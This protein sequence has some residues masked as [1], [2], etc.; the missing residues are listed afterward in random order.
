MRTFLI[1]GAVTALAFGGLAGCRP[2][3]PTLKGDA[4]AQWGGEG[5]PRFAPS[6]RLVIEHRLTDLEPLP[7]PLWPEPTPSS[8]GRSL[9]VALEVDEQ[10]RVSDVRIVEGNDYQW[11]LAA[12]QLRQKAVEQARRLR[13][14]PFIRHGRPVKAALSILIPVESSPAPPR[15]I[16]FPT[17]DP[18]AATIS[19]ERTGCFGTCPAYRVTLRG[20]GEVTWQ[21]ERFVVAPIDLRYRIDPAAVRELFDRVR[22][23]TFY[24]LRDDY[25]ARVTDLPAYSVTVVYGGQRKTVTDYAGGLVGMPYEVT[26]LEEA[27]D[28]AARTSRWIE[29]GPDTVPSLLAAGLD[30]SSPQAGEVVSRLIGGRGDPT[31]RAGR[32]AALE[33]IAAGAPINVAAPLGMGDVPQLPLVSAVELGDLDL[34]RRLVDLGALRRV[35][36][37]MLGRLVI[38]AAHSKDAAMMT[39]ILKLDPP[40]EAHDEWGFKDTPLSIAASGGDSDGQ[41]GVDI[42]SQRRTV[43]LLISKGADVRYRDSAGRTALH[44][45]GDP[46]IARMLIA[47]GAVIEAKSDWNETPLL[48]TDSEDVALVLIAA[49]ADLS[50][51]STM[52]ET[53]ES[54][55]RGNEWARV[56]AVLAKRKRQ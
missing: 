46:E 37:Q 18:D 25:Q 9:V 26:S 21:G 2:A 47:A 16:A 6:G 35:D 50:V 45:V 5:D 44:K 31:G 13:F 39:E 11:G 27:I 48:A 34:Y 29:P 17:G 3:A 43:A 14:R 24:G 52:D 15:P 49:G 23:M 42:A 7:A 54:R 41:F 51:T 55:A 4:A 38:A 53:V 22:A 33:L 12:R 28:R 8:F 20:D 1:A 10:G 56:L 36:R 30:P 19:L 32:D 40:L